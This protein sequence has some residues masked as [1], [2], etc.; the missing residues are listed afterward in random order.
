MVNRDCWCTCTCIASTSTST[1]DHLSVR[2]VAFRAVPLSQTLGVV[3]CRDA[4]RTDEV[5]EEDALI[6]DTGV[7]L[8]VDM[9]SP[10]RS[11]EI[12]G[13]SKRRTSEKA[14]EI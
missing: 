12:S 2:R 14:A 4:T 5:L 10:L 6:T 13:S 11:F 7:R 8:N 1:V 9:A 3:S